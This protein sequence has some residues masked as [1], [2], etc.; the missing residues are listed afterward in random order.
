[1]PN[2]SFWGS[3]IDSIELVAKKLRE[4]SSFKSFD[5]NEDSYIQPVLKGQDDP[6]YG[7]SVNDRASDNY[8]HFASLAINP[9]KGEKIEAVRLMEDVAAESESENLVLIISFRPVIGFFEEFY[10]VA[11]LQENIGIYVNGK[12]VGYTSRLKPSIDLSMLA[13]H[14]PA[15]PCG[16]LIVFCK[17]ATFEIDKCLRRVYPF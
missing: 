11:S 12:L 5:S 16:E 1:M 13:G 6:V 17:S 4:S 14:M 8:E 7:K 15:M 9:E 10:I 2:S 3:E